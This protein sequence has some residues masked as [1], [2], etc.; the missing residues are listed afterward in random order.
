M[1][2]AAP[3]TSTNDVRISKL[4][5]LG[6]AEIRAGGAGVNVAFGHDLS[7]LHSGD[8]ESQT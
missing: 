6:E 7:G 5:D 2:E 3:A 1:S 8:V 4:D